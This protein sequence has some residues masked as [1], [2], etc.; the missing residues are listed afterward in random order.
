MLILRYK[1]AK[2]LGYKTTK[3]RLKMEIRNL[4]IAIII[5]HTGGNPN[6]IFKKEI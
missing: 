2:H 4:A 1:K 5:T 3:R 6:M